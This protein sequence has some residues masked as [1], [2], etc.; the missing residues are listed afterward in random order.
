MHRD[1]ALL[2]TD[3]PEEKD[4]WDAERAKEGEHAEVVDVGQD[5]RLPRNYPVN[6]T[7]SLLALDSTNTRQRVRKDL[8]RA[9]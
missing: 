3:A 6:N 9:M 4:R 2:S 5:H 8:L 7:V 1:G